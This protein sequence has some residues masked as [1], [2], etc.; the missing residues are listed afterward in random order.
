MG[1]RMRGYGKDEKIIIKTY[2][3]VLYNNKSDFLL[4]FES[5]H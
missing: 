3:R 1:T 2:T 4:S 5:N